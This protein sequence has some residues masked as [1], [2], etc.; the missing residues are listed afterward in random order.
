MTAADCPG[1]PDFFKN[2]LRGVVE[3][4]CVI[5]HVAATTGEFEAGIS[6]NGQ[7]RAHLLAA[8]T[9]GV[10]QLI[11][12][13]NKMD[14]TEP[15]FHEDRFEECRKE[16]IGYA[17]K[18]GYSPKAVAVVPISG[19]LGDNLTESSQNMPW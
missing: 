14:N 2:T 6:K 12:A 11:V 4:D 18:C 15:P 13:V 1:H 16:V 5:L 7:A 19:F 10:K 8:Y 17:K 3:A 9:L